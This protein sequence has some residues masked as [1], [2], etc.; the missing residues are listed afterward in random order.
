MQCIICIGEI[1]NRLKKNF[2][3]FVT[4]FKLLVTSAEQK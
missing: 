1:V 2:V 3:V 4:T